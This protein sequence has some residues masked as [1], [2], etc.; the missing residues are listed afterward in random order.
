LE[1][2][3]FPPGT[4]EL[5]SQKTRPT[6]VRKRLMETQLSSIEWWL[7]VITATLGVLIVLELVLLALVA[8]LRTIQVI[9]KLY[10][11]LNMPAFNHVVDHRS[12]A[13]DR[14]ASR[15]PLQSVGRQR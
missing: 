12:T 2:Y 14:T 11:K 6:Q 15:P 7:N 10:T 13:V 1:A 3:G 4:G 9:T 8:T 5:Q